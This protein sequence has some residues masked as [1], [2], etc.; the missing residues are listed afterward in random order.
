VG[1][2]QPIKHQ[3]LDRYIQK[4]EMLTRY[5]HLK[6]SKK[7]NLSIDEQLFLQNFETAMQLMWVYKELDISNLLKSK[8]SLN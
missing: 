4:R 5:I 3:D 7:Y 1:K 6:F 2:N 8:T